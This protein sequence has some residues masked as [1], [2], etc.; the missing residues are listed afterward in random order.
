[1][2]YF[3]RYREDVMGPLNIST[4]SMESKGWSLGKKPIRGIEDG[5]KL[6]A[7]FDSPK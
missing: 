6:K 2:V 3:K 5:F 4:I 1:M 7:P